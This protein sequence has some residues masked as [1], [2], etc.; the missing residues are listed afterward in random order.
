MGWKLLEATNTRRED[1]PA[2]V[3]NWDIAEGLMVVVTVGLP[4]VAC[5]QAP[6]G[7]S[8]PKGRVGCGGAGGREGS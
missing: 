4:G 1:R 2:R 5:A 6:A 3:R 8:Y 7:S